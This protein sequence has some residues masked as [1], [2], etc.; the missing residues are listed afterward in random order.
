MNKVP[1]AR[2]AAELDSYVR[3]GALLSRQFYDTLPTFEA[4]QEGIRLYYPNLIKSIHMDKVAASFDAAQKAPV[5]K[6]HELSEVEKLLAQ[7][8]SELGNNNLNKAKELFE[9]ILKN[10]DANQ[11]EALY[12]LGIIASI[13]NDR[14]SAKEYFQQVLK[15]PSEDRSIKA[16]A[17]IY[18]GRLHDVEGNREDAILEYQAALDVG[19]N[20][21]NAR[22]VAQRGLK[23]PFNS[24]KR[25]PLP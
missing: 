3:S 7:A 14:K 22:E 21:R 11:G 25:A 4:S 12:G 24:R 13:Q 8:N 10:H 17:H 9:F 19:D 23:E 1:D 2:V 5:Q 15:S 20:T 18:M 6:P 16:W